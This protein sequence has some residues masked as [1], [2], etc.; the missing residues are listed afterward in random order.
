MRSPEELIS[1][2]KHILEQGSTK[3]SQATLGRSVGT[4]YYALFHT[5]AK[6]GADLLIGK[7]KGFRSNPAWRQVYRGLDHGPARKACEQKTTMEKFPQSIQ[8][9]GEMFVEMQ[10]ARSKADYDPDS[11]FSKFLVEDYIDRTREAMKGFGKA[12]VKD[13]KAFCAHVLFKSRA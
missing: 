7:T 8:N 12:D 9:F 6:T 1:L 4:V 2:S 10:K 3:P 11:K 5:L 13:Q